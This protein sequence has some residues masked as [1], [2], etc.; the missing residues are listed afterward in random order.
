[1]RRVL[2]IV[3]VLLASQ[4]P[5]LTSSGRAQDEGLKQIER[6]GGWTKQVWDLSQQGRF[7]DAELVLRRLIRQMENEGSPNLVSLSSALSMLSD[8]CL[9]TGQDEA[10]ERTAQRALA[11]ARNASDPMTIG[12]AL[13]CLGNV[14]DELGR[15][16]DAEREIRQALD[17]FQRLYGP[18][19]LVVAEALQNLAVV[20]VHTNRFLDAEP[21][22]KRVVAIRSREL[23]PRDTY[24]ADA[25]LNLA[26]TLERQDRWK[27]AEPY[28]RAALA[29]Y[30]AGGGQSK[31]ILMT[32]LHLVM[33]SREL[34]RW[35]DAVSYYQR[36]MA[37]A[38]QQYGSNDARTSE[39]RT[40]LGDIESARGH[41]AEAAVVYERALKGGEQALDDYQAASVRTNL[42]Q[43]YL[44]LGRYAEGEQ[45]A[46]QAIAG[47][48][49][50]E[51]NERDLYWGHSVRAEARYEQNKL[52]AAIDDL[53]VA[54]RL[55]EQFRSNLGGSE[56]E[57]A[58][59]FATAFRDD[60]VL[61]T[62][63]LAESGHLAEALAT[64]ERG[65]AR[66]LID[67]MQ[68]AHA[69][70]LAGLEPQQAQVLRDRRNRAE[71]KVARLERQRAAT[72]ADP[73]I[74]DRERQASREELEVALA[75]ARGAL[76]EAHTELRN[77]S[78]AYRQALSN[79]F[80]PAALERID[81]W[82]ADRQFQLLYYTVSDRS[83]FVVSCGRQADSSTIQH[84]QVAPDQARILG[85]E[86]G[87]LTGEKLTAVLQSAGGIL[88]MLSTPDVR[89]ELHQ[90]L[91]ALAQVLL[92]VAEREALSSGGCRGLVIVP[93]GPLVSLPF[94]ALVIEP[95]ARP[96][97]LLDVGPP[98]LYAPSA[99]VLLNLAQRSI[100][101]QAAA[102]N[103]QPVL[104]VANPI[105][106]TAAPLSGSD[107]PASRGQYRSVGGTLAELPFSGTESAW[108]AEGF[109]KQ[110][111]SVAALRRE[112]ATEHNV[113][114]NVAG[115]RIVHFACHGLADQ[116]FGNFFG[117]LALTPGPN[118]GGS[119]SDD[120][121]LTLPEIYELNLT[122]CE[123]AILSACQTNYG[124]Q[125]KGE[126]VWALSRGFLVAGSR[127][128]VAS[129]WI[130]DDEAAASLISVFCSDVAKVEGKGETP[131]YAAA[132]HRA[133]R[134]VRG[135]AKWASP[136]YWGTFVLVGPN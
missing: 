37:A 109:K 57:R 128:V 63:A 66:A 98:V 91:A 47:V 24:V 49:G 95:A 30:Q 92:P 107:E 106:R 62:R 99:T 84:L 26:T 118:G 21:L 12:A 20:L 119:S 11:I 56:H 110:G 27:E 78:P 13:Q 131:D 22:L 130:V 129:N 6:V 36:M 43:L 82:L 74:S 55:A 34:R 16:A 45:L 123:L 33:V 67:Q 113:R 3:L 64:A 29:V 60:Y 59:S 73:G 133:K 70:L 25:Y 77:A 135:Q 52:T 79:D 85:V 10:A 18:D 87:P 71:T 134:W 9:Q 88:P 61:L 93:D 1:M 42:A 46:S 104:S 80:Q 126:G 32:L 86:P 101:D 35:E 132:L 51:A 14:H 39:L 100:G 124:P 7:R 121:F 97:Y 19:S 105:Y 96:K 8:A 114:G 68:I 48:Q 50:R 38:N 40:L 44:K 125:Q 53:Q 102:P 103:K 111:V 41:Y 69:D 76:V 28:L 75:A 15:F 108:L 23:G 58:Q 65:R 31:R 117:S 120:G 112:L 17:V 4:E 83:A 122:Q 116:A 2:Y 54:L 136:Y 94:E 72:N 89:P 81:Q 5:W 127:R 115:R 90:R